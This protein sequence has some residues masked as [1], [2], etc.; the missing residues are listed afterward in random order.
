MLFI[1]FTGQSVVSIGGHSMSDCDHEEADSR[2]CLHIKDALTYGAKNILVRTVDTD[3][4]IILVGVFFTLQDQF[5]GFAL[6][7]AFGMGK[8]FSTS[9]SKP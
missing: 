3:V 6:W 8:H 1:L 7:V 5:P 4:I 9:V 2:M